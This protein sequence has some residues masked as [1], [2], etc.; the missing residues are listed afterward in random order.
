[1][2]PPSV[3]KWNNFVVGKHFVNIEMQNNSDELEDYQI[4]LLASKHGIPAKI[5]RHDHV[6]CP[7]TFSQI[8]VYKA[9]IYPI[10]CHCGHCCKIKINID[11]K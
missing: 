5:T 9:L 1:M 2:N 3:K 7:I 4:L 11:L 8:R 10:D 6:I